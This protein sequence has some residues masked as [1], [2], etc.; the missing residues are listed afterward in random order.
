MNPELMAQR[1]KMQMEIMLKDSDLK[2]NER[3]IVEAEVALREI[4]H[5]QT[6][7]QTEFIMKENLSK[8][9]N[10]EHVQ[11]QAELIKLRHQMNSLGR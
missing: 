9:L 6:Q 1:K 8:R 4:K 5:K 7:L 10:A 3:A 2:K 11:I